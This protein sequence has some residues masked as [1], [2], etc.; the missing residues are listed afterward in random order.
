MTIYA[1]M[2][3]EFFY[4]DWL[5]FLKSEIKLLQLYENQELRKQ[6]ALELQKNMAIN[7]PMSH[8]YARQQVQRKDWSKFL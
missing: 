3:L 4:F 7:V 2:Y 1:L 5:L 6:K 8:L